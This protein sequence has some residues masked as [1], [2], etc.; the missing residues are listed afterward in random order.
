LA[1]FGYSRVPNS[2]KRKTENELFVLMTKHFYVSFRFLWIRKKTTLQK[3][4]I[5]MQELQVHLIFYK[6]KSS[7]TNESNS[8]YNLNLDYNL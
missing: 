6:H 8:F 2:T 7:K 3:T 5:F 4:Q 1:E